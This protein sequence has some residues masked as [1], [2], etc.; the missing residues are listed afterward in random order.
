MS[1]SKINKS[2]DYSKVEGLKHPITNRS[3]I[4]FVHKEKPQLFSM[5]FYKDTKKQISTTGVFVEKGKNYYYSFNDGKYHQKE[6]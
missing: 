3:I 2:S 4:V 6:M 5:A 1:Y